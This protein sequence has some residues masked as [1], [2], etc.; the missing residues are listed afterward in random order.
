MPVAV[1]VSSVG[2]VAAATLVFRENGVLRVA[3]IV[4][5]SFTFT[6][7]GPMRIAPP[8]PIFAREVHRMNNPTRSIVATSDLVPRL[9]GADVL[10]RS[11]PEAVR[12]SR[13]F[14]AGLP[15]SSPFVSECPWASPGVGVP[16][17]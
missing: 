4:K 8:E 11:A 6:H 17:Q 2:P 16:L 10:L 1:P 3:A 5:A 14:S 13:A 7:H 15:G 9:P 12:R